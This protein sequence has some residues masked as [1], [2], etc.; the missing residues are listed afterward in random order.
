LAEVRRE[1]P[2][3]EVQAGLEGGMKLDL[4]AV[5]NGLLGET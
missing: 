1:V 3:G 2:E 5:V 4:E